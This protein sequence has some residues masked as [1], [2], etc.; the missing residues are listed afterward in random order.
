VVPRRQRIPNPENSTVNGNSSVVNPL[1]AFQRRQYTICH[2]YKRGVVMAGL[3]GSL[4]PGL[5]KAT[6]GRLWPPVK[7]AARLPA[8]VTRH[9]LSLLLSAV[10]YFFVTMLRIQPHG[11]IK[12][13]KV[14]E[15]QKVIDH[16]YA[17]VEVCIDTHPLVA[18]RPFLS[19]PYALPV[20]LICTFCLSHSRSAL[21]R[22]PAVS[23]R[24][25]GAKG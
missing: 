20:S 5:L 14:V 24:C 21:A 12:V 17:Q 6:V 25:P 1:T 3:F 22:S 15:L 9:Y 4:V 13:G 7:A 8:S 19:Y 16:L 23:W 10:L 18:C 2:T 11:Y